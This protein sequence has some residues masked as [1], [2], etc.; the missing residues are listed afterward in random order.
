M[1]SSRSDI[2]LCL[3]TLLVVAGCAS[4]KVTN[5]DPLVYGQLPRPD[6]IWVYDF[7]ATPA[8]VPADSALAGQH[9]PH[10]T[11]QTDEQIAAGRK[12]GAEIAAEL[13]KEIQAMG[14]PAARATAQTKPQLNDLLIKGYLLSINQGDAVERVAIGF[15]GVRRS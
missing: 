3:F 5:R 12:A 11:P 15:G 8:D 13:V 6:H 4:T 9:S 10:P 7:V 2:V 1:K 14:L